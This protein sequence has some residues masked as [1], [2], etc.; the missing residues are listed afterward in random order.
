MIHV[1]G[2]VMNA[3]AEDTIEDTTLNDSADSNQVNVVLLQVF[4]RLAAS[5]FTTLSAPQD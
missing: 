2:K 4:L 1:L 5:F 3:A